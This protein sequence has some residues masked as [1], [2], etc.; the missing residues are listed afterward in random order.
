MKFKY[1]DQYISKNRE[2]RRKHLNLKEKCIE[3]GGNSTK[4]QA[5]LA[6]FLK[7]T[8]PIN[9]KINLCHACNNGKCSNV[10]HLYW[11]TSQDNVQ[12]IKESGKWSSLYSRTVKK[13]GINY[14]KD[15]CRKNGQNNKGKR[16]LKK[17]EINRRLNLIEKIN[18]N[19]WG[20]TNKVAEVLNISHTQARRFINKYI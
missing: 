7:T 5:L 19:E 3:I 16:L 9:K 11:G 12:D 15:I 14:M 1:I 2:D 18:L 4:F 8:I 20:S 13:Y 10:K 6:Y 17:D